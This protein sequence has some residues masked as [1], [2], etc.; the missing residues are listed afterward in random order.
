MSAQ[1]QAVD[2]V[3][4]DFDRLF[5]PANTAPTVRAN[6]TQESENKQ[7]KRHLI[8]GHLVCKA[9]WNYWKNPT[10]FATKSV[11]WQE[12]PWTPQLLNMRRTVQASRRT[13][14]L[15]GV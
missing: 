13:Q 1:N 15:G 9:D 2:I 7:N 10:E 6:A 5:L 3:T 11:L 14:R 4:K 8:K 12:R